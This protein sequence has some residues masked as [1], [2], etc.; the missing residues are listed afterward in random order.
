M[1]EWCKNRYAAD[2]GKLAELIPKY[3]SDGIIQN[4]TKELYRAQGQIRNGLEQEIIIESIEVHLKKKMSGTIPPDLR[5]V[6]IFFEMKCEFD[7]SLDINVKDRIKKGYEFQ[8]EVQGE[9]DTGA[10]FNAWHLDKDIKEAGDNPAKV[11]HPSYHFQAGGSKLEDKEISGAIF[12]GAPR[13]PHP[14]MDVILGLHFIL[15]NYCSKKD[16]PFLNDLFGD[17]EY[18][19]II[20]RAQERMFIPYF[21]AFKDDNIHQDFTMDKVFPLAV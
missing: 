20:E 8:I 9:H 19:E 10:H 17:Y 1:K 2:L 16:Y 3:D 13:L 5:S 14:P 6:T 11:T 12:L 7:M 4:A 15:S 18:E 21:Q